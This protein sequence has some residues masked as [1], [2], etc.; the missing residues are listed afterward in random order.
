MVNI[1]TIEDQRYLVDVG[2]GAPVPTHPLP[3]IPG[4]LCTGIAPQSLQLE[5]KSLLHH[6]DPSQRAW[7]YSYRENHDTP[8]TEA[9]SFV[10]IEFFPQD[11]E[12]MN[13]STMTLPQSFFTQ[14]VVCV[15]IILNEE[16]NEMEG[17]LTLVH[18]EVKT[19]IRGVSEVVEKLEREEQRIKALE[20]W[21]SIVLTEAEKK[22]IIGLATE[23]R[24]NPAQ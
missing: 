17:I 2:F 6:T 19:K 11:Y 7:V 20:K 18:N 23:L 15:K 13:L 5:H 14:T 21:F 4:H 9:Y 10:E 22:G 12:V 1:V 3:L 24:G 8:W 16:S